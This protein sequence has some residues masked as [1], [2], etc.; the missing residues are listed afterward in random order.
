MSP[1]PAT[2]SFSVYEIGAFSGVCLS[3]GL[4]EGWIGIGVGEQSQP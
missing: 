4:I 3:P 1:S 2:V